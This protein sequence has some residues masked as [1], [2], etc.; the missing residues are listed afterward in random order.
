M[1]CRSANLGRPKNWLHR[2]AGTQNAKA[3]SRNAGTR[4]AKAFQELVPISDIFSYRDPFDNCPLVKNL[5]PQ[6]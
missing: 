4:D 5:I 1:E 6:K 2:N 3:K